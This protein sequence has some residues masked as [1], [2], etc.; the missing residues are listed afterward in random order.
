MLVTIAVAPPLCEHQ[1]Q[2]PGARAERARALK[3][4]KKSP[5]AAPALPLSSSEIYSG[6][7]R[8]SQRREEEEEVR[9]VAGRPAGLNSVRA[10]A[11]EGEPGT[12]R[13]SPLAFERFS[14]ANG[15]RGDE[16]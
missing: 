4:A 15:R 9:H 10:D 7:L 3:R 11:R 8:S 6:F 5:A 14:W 12:R 13:S 16:P 2:I 1:V